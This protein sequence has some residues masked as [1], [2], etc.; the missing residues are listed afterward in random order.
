MYRAFTVKFRRRN[1]RSTAENLTTRGPVTQA[2]LERSAVDP[3]NVIQRCLVV[4]FTLAKPLD[5]KCTWQSEGATG[6]RFRPRCVDNQAPR[7]HYATARLLPRFCIN[8]RDR[9]VEDHPSTEHG[10]SPNSRPLS[11]HGT[12]ANECVVLDKNRCRLRGLKHATK[13]DAARQMPFLP[14]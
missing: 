6:I 8:D 3:K 11:H 12:A 9:R 2:F 4:A 5:N 14:T 10:P 7:R 1:F 13:A